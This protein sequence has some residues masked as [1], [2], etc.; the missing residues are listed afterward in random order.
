M[1]EDKQENKD[2]KNGQESNLPADAKSSG[3]P[4]TVSVA[5]SKSSL[6]RDEKQWVGKPKPVPYPTN[7]QAEMCPVVRKY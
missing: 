1:N 6:W 7:W 5:E 4:L 3:N 2:P